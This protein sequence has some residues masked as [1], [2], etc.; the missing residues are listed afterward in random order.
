LGAFR[1][2]RLGKAVHAG[3]PW[4]Q[5]GSGK[6]FAKAGNKLDP[7]LTLE[8]LIDDGIAVAEH[9]SRRFE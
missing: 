7:G 9:V 4:D 1:R 2:S 5:T 3:A 8:Q 6:T